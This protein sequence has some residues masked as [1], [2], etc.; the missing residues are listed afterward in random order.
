MNC[1]R[2]LFHTTSGFESIQIECEYS[3]FSPRIYKM[4]LLKG[5]EGDIFLMIRVSL[6]GDQLASRSLEE[7][8]SHRRALLSA[9]MS[10]SP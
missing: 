3:A 4:F 5:K 1:F 10:T 2:K 7:Y 9:P 6:M 8:K